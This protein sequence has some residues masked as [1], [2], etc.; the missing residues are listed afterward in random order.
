MFSS[1]FNQNIDIEIADTSGRNGFFLR[2]VS[3][4]SLRDGVRSS[5]TRE[6]LGVSQLAW[7]FP[8]VPPEELEEVELEKRQVMDGSIDKLLIF[9]C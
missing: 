3:G 9:L 6:G 4:L 1:L 8:G 5:V 7:V 2:R